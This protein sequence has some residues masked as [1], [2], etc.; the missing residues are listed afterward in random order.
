MFQTCYGPRVAEFD[1]ILDKLTD[2]RFRLVEKIIQ[3]RI[4]EGRLCSSDPNFLALSVCCLMDQ[5][6]NLFSRR[7][8]PSRYMTNDLANALVHL[9]LQGAGS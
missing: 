5:P 4:A 1:G 9:F 6:M 7:S 8:R 2:R 3:E